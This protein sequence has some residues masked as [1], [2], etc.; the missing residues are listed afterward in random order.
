[1][2]NRTEPLIVKE[3]STTESGRG[4]ATFIEKIWMMFEVWADRSRGRR[5]LVAMSERQLKDIGL[6]RGD[7]VIEYEKPF[8]RP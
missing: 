3:R 6:S 8:W 7:A 2:R 5:R 4:R 1:M